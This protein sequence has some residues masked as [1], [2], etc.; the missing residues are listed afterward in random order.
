MSALIDDGDGTVRIHN[1]IAAGLCFLGVLS[2]LNE[3]KKRWSIS[4]KNVGQKNVGFLNSLFQF[5]L[6][7]VS[8][9]YESRL[10]SRDHEIEPLLLQVPQKE[11]LLATVHSLWDE[12]LWACIALTREFGASRDLDSWLLDTLEATTEDA[13]EIEGGSFVMATHP[14]TA[15]HDDLTL[16]SC[17]LLI[18]VESLK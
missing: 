4:I 8:I 9:F 17:P 18:D 12:V 11:S 16:L 14:G 6:K 7:R 10:Q 3:T 15:C 2:F 1:L 13:G 5:F